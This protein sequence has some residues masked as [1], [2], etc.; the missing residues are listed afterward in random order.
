MPVGKQNQG[1]LVVYKLWVIPPW[2]EI[3]IYRTK[4]LKGVLE[5]LIFILLKYLES[6]PEVDKI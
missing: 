4:N 2:N 3:F 6:L 5:Q 1:F